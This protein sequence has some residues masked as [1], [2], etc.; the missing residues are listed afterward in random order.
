MEQCDIVILAAGKGTRMNSEL[1]KVLVP[2][3]GRPLIS[4]LLDSV[5]MVAQKTPIIVV[6]HGREL[7]ENKLGEN[8]CY[9]I[10]HKQRG[11]AHAV[12]SALPA[13]DGRSLI[14]LYGDMPFITPDTIKQL[15]TSHNKLSVPLTLGTV[16]VPD[17]S[18]WRKNFERLG[19]ILRDEVGNIEAIREYK[20]ATEAEKN[21]HEVNP[22]YF[23]FDVDWIRRHIGEVNNNNTQEEFY[24]TDLVALAREEGH[25]INSVSIKPREAL[26]ANTIDELAVLES[27]R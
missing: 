19:R 10:Q 20:D 14:V 4:Y 21:I 18:D 7:I 3:S 24:L 9:A 25:K 5:M 17:F 26:G 22:A 15:V 1:P 8:Y 16:T 11:T 12:S 13:V 6:G 2:L 27:Q 23:V